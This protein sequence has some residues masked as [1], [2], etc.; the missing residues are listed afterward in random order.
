MAAVT[1]RLSSQTGQSAP[2]GQTIVERN[3]MKARATLFRNLFFAIGLLSASCGRPPD[4]LEL[5]QSTLT[6]GNCTYS[7]TDICFCTGASGSGTCGVVS[8]STRFAMNLSTHPTLSSLNDQIT[9]IKVGTQA[10]GKICADPG[11]NG[12]CGYID[13]STNYDDLSFGTSCPGFACG[14]FGTDF[15]WGCKCMNNNI[16]SI[17]VDPL[18]ACNSP[19][20]GQVVI[21]EDPNCNNNMIQ[22]SG[23]SKDC[24][25]LGA[26]TYPDYRGNASS[27]SSGGGYGLNTDVISSVRVTSG[28]LLELYPNLSYGGTKYST[29][30]DVTTLPG[31][32][33][34]QTTSIKVCSAPGPC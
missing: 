23:T 20:S 5:V 7:S 26:G 21:C 29:T 17:R 11:G 12:N 28:A 33:D 4:E 1:F 32:I 31:S 10:R 27:G 19:N 22:P 9:S 15:G 16:T 6:Y 30:A 25:V 2:R 24:V 8:T 13:S 3:I 34:D 18:T 14:S